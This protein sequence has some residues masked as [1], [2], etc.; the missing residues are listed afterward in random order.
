MRDEFELLLEEEETQEVIR[1][2]KDSDFPRALKDI[3]A[4]PERAGEG[5]EDSGRS[6]EGD[7]GRPQNQVDPL[8]KHGWD[9]VR[10]K[11]RMEMEKGEFDTW[12]KN[13]RLVKV[14][15]GEFVFEASNSYVRDWLEE[16]LEHTLVDKLTPL[17]EGQG[18]NKGRAKFILR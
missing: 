6:W 11:M 3:L 18:G 17:V 5:M 15:G 8:Y 4:E 14:E 12:A 13:I 9:V 2:L 7:W 1:S 16:H 10:G